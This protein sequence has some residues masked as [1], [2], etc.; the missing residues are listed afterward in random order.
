[1]KLQLM[2]CVSVRPWPHSNITTWVLFSWA[3]RV[4][5]IWFW[6]Q[7]GM[8]LKGP[9]FHHLEPRLRGKKGLL[10]DEK[11]QDQG[12][13][14]PIIRSFIHRLHDQKNCVWFPAGQEVYLFPK[15]STL[16]LEP[17]KPLTQVTEPLSQGLKRSGYEVHEGLKMSEAILSLPCMPSWHVQGK[18]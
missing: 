11:H 3:L 18:Y 1:M 14:E 10:N 13:L 16:P 12:G 6:D 4:L 7:S 2:F 5:E 15:A 9:D 8:L 17:S